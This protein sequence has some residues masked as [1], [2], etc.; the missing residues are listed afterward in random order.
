MALITQVNGKTLNTIDQGY[1]TGQKPVPAGLSSAD[2]AQ[3]S[4][5]A[6][7]ISAAPGVTGGV[8]PSTNV[9]VPGNTPVGLGDINQLT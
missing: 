3:I 9:V 8:D 1:V 2:S 6:G 5:I 4:G 7:N